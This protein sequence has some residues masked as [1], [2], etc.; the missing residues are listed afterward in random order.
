MAD[1]GHAAQTSRPLNEDRRG[2]MAISPPL[3]PQNPRH[4]NCS[5]ECQ[6]QSD[7]VTAPAER[8]GLGKAAL[9]VGVRSQPSTPFGFPLN[10]PQRVT[11][12]L[13]CLIRSLGRQN[14]SAVTRCG[15]FRGTPNGVEGWNRTPNG[16]AALP[17]PLRS[18][19]RDHL[20]AFDTR[21]A[22]EVPR[23]LGQQWRANGHEAVDP[24]SMAS[25]SA[26]RSTISHGLNSILATD[27]E[28][29][30]PCDFS[31]RVC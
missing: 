20:I 26:P 10:R 2:S 7:L 13:F 6:M 24:R 4:L 29:A 31:S 9:P 14:S 5:V 1:G 16:R 27:Y 30:G 17:R 3:L 12:L 22:I 15:R 25:T 11:A 18:P 19:V 21:R 28:T 23:I 8:R